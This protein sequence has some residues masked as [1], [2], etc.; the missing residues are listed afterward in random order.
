MD[1]HQQVEHLLAMD[2]FKPSPGV[3]ADL[4]S[5]HVDDR[6]INVLLVLAKKHTLEVSVIKTGHPLGPT[7]PGGKNN[8]HYFYRAVDIT[9]IDG[10]SLV[11]Y[12]TD[13]DILDVGRLLHDLPP[14]TRPD[15]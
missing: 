5:G 2:T 8:S 7:T 15:H 1:V 14:Q 12:A 4:E 11:G 3:R 10:K 13:P 6:I 9:A